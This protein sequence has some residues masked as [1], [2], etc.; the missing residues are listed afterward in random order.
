LS[1][2]ILTQNAPD[3]YES[4]PKQVEVKTKKQ[5]KLTIQCDEMSVH[6]TP[7][8]GRREAS[9]LVQAASHMVFCRQ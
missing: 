4:V 7:I 3:K 5:G 2:K 1:K 6:D 8:R 9:A